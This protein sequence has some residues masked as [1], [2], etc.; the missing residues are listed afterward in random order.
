MG[1]KSVNIPVIFALVDV[2]PLQGKTPTHKHRLKKVAAIRYTPPKSENKFFM[3]IVISGGSGF[4]GSRLAETLLAQGHELTLLSR[5]GE[6]VSTGYE[7]KFGKKVTGVTWDATKEGLPA[8]A[9]KN[10]DAI[11][12]LAG[13]CWLDGR[14]SEDK[15]TK[16]KETRV[17]GTRHLIQALKERKGRPVTLIVASSAMIYGEQGEKWI[18]ESS[19]AGDDFLAKVYAETEKE[20]R[21]LPYGMGRLVLLRFGFLL[22]PQAA[23]F[24]H[25]PAFGGSNASSKWAS[26][27]HYQDAINAITACLT[28]QAVEG[29]LNV[30]SPEPS[31]HIDFVEFIKRQSGSRLS[32]SAL[33]PV[34]RL[35]A[36]EKG[37]SI[38]DSHR[39][40]PERL[41][42]MGFAFEYPTLESLSN[43]QNAGKNP[44]TADRSSRAFSPA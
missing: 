3:K 15:K 27:I 38:S 19:P 35:F 14:W 24:A 8:T 37:D 20:A 23:V 43:L 41:Q 32:L 11:I 25:A 6:A 30:C 7:K 21:S 36:G 9:I 1:S 39:V 22:G 26:W 31:T 44:G 29:V 33:A 34:A 12:H 5:K 4:L 13:E 17:L 18:S 16:I 40:R 10:I 2:T 42:K 28:N